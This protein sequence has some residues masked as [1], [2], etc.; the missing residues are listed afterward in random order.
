M[1]EKNY[2]DII[3][4]SCPTSERHPRMSRQARA[5]QFAP[6]AALTGYNEAILEAARLTEREREL[7]EDMEERLNRWQR[8]LA[9]IVDSTP[10]VKV[11]YFIPDKKKRGGSYK[12]VE[13]RLIGFSAFDRTI[14]LDRGITIPILDIKSLESE[15]F[16]DMID[17][18]TD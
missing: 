3:D 8:M 9:A 5:A 1:T 4:L 7:G 15:L 16:A 12:T 14:T 10:R 13:A 18:M 2:D 11:I 17:E 6:F